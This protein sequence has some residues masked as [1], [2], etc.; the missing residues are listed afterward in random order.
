[1]FEILMQKENV[2]LYILSVVASVKVATQVELQ[3]R[4]ANARIS[5]IGLRVLRWVVTIMDSG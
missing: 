1:M 3:D 5:L 2:L 4:C